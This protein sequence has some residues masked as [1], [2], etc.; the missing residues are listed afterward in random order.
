[1]TLREFFDYLG[2]NPLPLLFFFV[3]I[4]FAA[5]LAGFIGRGEGHLSPW[6]YFYGLLVYLVCIPGVFAV[7]LSVYFFLFE[8]RSILDTNVLMQILPFVS[9]VLT[10]AIIRGNVSLDQVPGFDRLSGLVMM[11]LSVFALMFVVDR[12]RIIVFSYM[13]IQYLA[14]IVVGMLILFRYG[15][16]RLSA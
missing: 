10:I 12:T 9:M 5:L 15:L 6:K 3:G 16:K 7:A 1:M 2:N 4:P 8:R 14:L 13:P 11:I